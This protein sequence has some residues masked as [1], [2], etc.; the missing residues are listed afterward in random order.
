MP[1]KDIASKALGMAGQ[2]SGPAGA[3]GQAQGTAPAPSGSTAQPLPPTGLQSQIE[4]LNRFYN[5]AEAAP[6]GVNARQMQFAQGQQAL[7][8]QAPAQGSTNLNQLAQSL[9]QNYGLS[10]GSGDLVDAEGNFL[11][12]P[13]QIAAAS[14]GAETMGTAAA[15]MNL[16]AEAIANRQQQ[17]AQSQAQATMQTGLGL[18]Q[19][20]GRGSLAAM[21]SGMYEGLASLYA[22]QDYEAADFSYFIQKEQMDIQMEIMRKQEKA[23]KRRGRASMVMGGI[24]LIAAIPTGGATLPM[25]AQGL[26]EG[27]ASS[28]W[29]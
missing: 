18:V 1:L 3:G 27:Y 10:I 25:A 14:G 4:S 15:K 22:N 9:A 7:P 16:I 26:S 28:G 21:Q 19:E 23:A 11:M 17:Q 29:F 24:G 5:E 12:T 20:R 8:A 2:A 13:D 6:Y